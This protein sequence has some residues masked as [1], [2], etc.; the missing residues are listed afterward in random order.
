M[1]KLLPLL[2]ILT[3]LLSAPFAI[4]A[5]PLPE[6]DRI[7]DT[8]V[9]K[10]DKTVIDENIG[11]ES[12]TEDPPKTIVLTEEYYLTTL[13]KPAAMLFALGIAVFAAIGVLQKLITDKESL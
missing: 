3:L 12:E 11:G 8:L 9:I 1:P 4:H 10:P 6:D 2:L 13:I 5:D 7:G